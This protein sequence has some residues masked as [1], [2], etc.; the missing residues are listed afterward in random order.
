LQ[1]HR[2]RIRFFLHMS[3]F[4][5]YKKQLETALQK[6]KDANAAIPVK[7]LPQDQ[8]EALSTD[9]VE[10]LLGIVGNLTKEVNKL[11]P[12]IVDNLPAVKACQD[13]LLTQTDRLA[14]QIFHDSCV[15]ASKLGTA[16]DRVTSTFDTPGCA[17]LVRHGLVSRI[18]RRIREWDKLNVSGKTLKDAD[19]EKSSKRL[20]A[21]WTS[22]QSNEKGVDSDM[23]GTTDDEGAL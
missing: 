4:D 12:T 16:V 15:A 8:L 22:L 13:Q 3:Y 1:M 18:N 20:C 6:F 7:T 9:Q 14:A 2:Y 10:D 17:G 21:E 19:M 5:D 23:D 11:Q